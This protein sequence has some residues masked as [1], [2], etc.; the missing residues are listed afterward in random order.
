MDAQFHEEGVRISEHVHQVADRRTLIPSHIS[1]ARLKQRLG[2]GQYAL[3]MKRLSGAKA[4]R[5]D[6]LGK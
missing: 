1:H 6:F 4:K 3:A 5:L 2:D